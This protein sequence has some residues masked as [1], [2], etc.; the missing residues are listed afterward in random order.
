PVTPWIASTGGAPGSP[1]R[2][3]LRT[4]IDGGSF[5]SAASYAPATGPP[6]RPAG[7]EPCTGRRLPQ[8]AGDGPVV[9]RRSGE[10]TPRAA[11]PRAG[12]ASRQPRGRRTGRATRRPAQR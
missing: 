10:A 2:W 1:L 4:A 6:P 11:S 9:G 7:A 12:R 5:Q 8:E 3:A